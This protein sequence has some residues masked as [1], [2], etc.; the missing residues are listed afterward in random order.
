[1]T[2]DWHATYLTDP[3]VLDA[4]RRRCA[5]TGED[6][7]SAAATLARTMPPG[8]G[9]HEA[10]GA[11]AVI[12]PSSEMEA[13]ARQDS[14]GLFQVQPHREQVPAFTW[15]WSGA[16]IRH[17]TDVQ[18]GYRGRCHDWTCPQSNPRRDLGAFFSE[19]GAAASRAYHEAREH[20]LSE[21]LRVVGERGG[22]RATEQPPIVIVHDEATGETTQ[23]TSEATQWTSPWQPEP[24]TAPEPPGDTL[25]HLLEQASAGALA[26]DDADA[27][28]AIT[29]ARRRRLVTAPSPALSGRRRRGAASRLHLTELGR[30]ELRRM[31]R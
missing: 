19:C 5:Q 10:A 2:R 30:I 31:Q 27:H 11:R 26:L 22:F 25:L 3:T 21:Y 28:P 23:W 6:G 8:F 29:E 24:R 4:A 7:W 1:M 20:L 14:V 17:P 12:A 9:S 13:A 18:E 16:T 15:L